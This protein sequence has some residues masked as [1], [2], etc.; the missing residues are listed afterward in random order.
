MIDINS[1]I[2]LAGLLIIL[3]AFVLNIFQKLKAN[4]KIYLLLNLLGSAALAYYALKLGSMPFLVLQVVW[5]F[6]SGYKL[7]SL[8]VK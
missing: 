3:A 4:S 5:A 1:V 7:I 2:G 8:I 6:F